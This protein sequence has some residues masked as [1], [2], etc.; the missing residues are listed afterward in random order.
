M[1]NI[2]KIIIVS[3]TLFILSMPIFAQE[4]GDQITIGT[5]RK[6]H[7]NILNEDR[8]VLVN[9]PNGYREATNRYPSQPR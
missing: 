1:D 4:D 2:E 6:L 8:L 3:M 9:L 7:S 5:Y